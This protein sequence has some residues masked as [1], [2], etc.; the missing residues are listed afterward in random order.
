M[1]RESEGHL[2]NTTENQEMI[3]TMVND[4]EN[5]IG[6]SKSKYTELEWYAQTLD[7]GKQLWASVRNGK[8]ENCGMNEKERPFDKE[9]GLC[10]NTPQKK[11]N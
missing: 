1:F 11:K 10:R 4:E 2:P 6:K 5:F 9:T 7:N 3:L 8:I